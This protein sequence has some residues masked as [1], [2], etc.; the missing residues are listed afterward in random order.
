[1]LNRQIEL[2][3]APKQ[4]RYTQSMIRLNCNEILNDI[5]INTNTNVQGSLKCQHNNFELIS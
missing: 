1:M 3:T 5:S 4:I 2:N